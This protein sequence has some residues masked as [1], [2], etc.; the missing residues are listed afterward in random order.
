MQGRVTFV[1]SLIALLVLTAASS[2]PASPQ[3]E[4]A[5]RR[6]LIGT[7]NC[8]YTVGSRGGTYTTTWESVLDNR[9]LKQ[10]Y[11]QPSTPGNPGFLAQYFI[12]YDET[13][14]GWVRFGVMTTGQYFA[15]RMRDTGNG[16]W[17]WK[18]VSF[19][20]GGPADSTH[21]DATFTKK[22]N[23]EY[24]VDGPTYPKGGQMETEHHLC[25]KVP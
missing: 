24:A 25:K 21:A 3:D 11:N 1:A 17:A 18:Y 15:I 6:F 7:W 10:A 2:R 5:S 14:A 16:G 8:S 22:S 4:L 23:V 9:W 19:F 13:N 12:G 20:R